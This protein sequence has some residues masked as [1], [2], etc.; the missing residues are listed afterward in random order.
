M[1][2]MKRSIAIS[3]LSA[4]GCEEELCCSQIQYTITCF[5]L[6]KGTFFSAH[7]TGSEM[8]LEKQSLPGIWSEEVDPRDCL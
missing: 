7:A 2:H 8:A 4:Y 6:L 3:Y 1:R 5:H